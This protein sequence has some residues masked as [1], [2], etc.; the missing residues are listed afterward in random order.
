MAG[1]DCSVLIRLLYIFNSNS[2][3]LCT[4]DKS[5]PYEAVHASPLASND[6]LIL[7]GCLLYSI[8]GLILTDIVA[9]GVIK[10]G[11][12]ALPAIVDTILTAS[13]ADSDFI[14]DSLRQV[15]GPMRDIQTLHTR[16]RRNIPNV[17]PKV[18]SGLSNLVCV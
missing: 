5:F 1:V 11:V 14:A 4:I 17:F 7:P 13:P 9:Y 12:C 6:A 10:E 16:V 18:T 15:L 3:R 2:S 8:P